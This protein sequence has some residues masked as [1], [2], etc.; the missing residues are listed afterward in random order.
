MTAFIA[1]ITAA[2]LFAIALPACVDDAPPATPETRAGES[3]ADPVAAAQESARLHEWLEAAF[4]EQLAFSPMAQTSLGRKT[5]YDKWDQATDQA[6]TDLSA[7][8]KTKLAQLRSSFDPKTLDEQGKLNFRLYEYDLEQDDRA[9]RWRESGYNISQFGGAH[10]NTPPFLINFHRVDT[11]DDAAAYVVRLET[12]D[13]YLDQ[14]REEFEQRAGKGVMP[15]AWAF[16]QMIE[17][18][19][20]IITGAPFDGGAPSAL[21]AD[22][23]GKIDA[24]DADPAAK[25]ALKERAA[26]ALINEVKPAYER[27]IA[28]FEAAS[29][30][31]T[32]DDGVWKLPDGAAYY[33]H[34]VAA[35]TTTELTADE[36]HK[37][38]LREL[39]RIHAEMRKI[40]TYVGYEGSLEEFLVFLRTDPQFF[41]Q[42][43]DDGRAAYLAEATRVIDEVKARLD[44]LFIAK[45]KAD[46][47]VKR[48]EPF[49]EKAAGIAFY[50][51]PAPDGSR[52]GIYY[53]NLANMA[54]MPKFQLQAIAYHEGAPGHHMQIAIAQEIE[55]M[56]S[57]R[58]FGGYGAYS[59]GWGLY[60][61]EVPKEMGLYTD[62]YSDFGRL[63]TE[64]WRAVRLIVDT[65]IHS[66]KWTREQ[67]I[68]FMVKSVPV[69]EEQARKEIE[70]YVVIPG[71]A[72]AYMIGKLKIKELR[73]RAEEALR[74][75]FDLREFHDEVLANGS[76]PLDVLDDLIDEWIASK[77]AA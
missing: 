44:E 45:P 8:R 16:P 28:A 13:D 32:N 5:N 18:A 77:K 24:L 42:D 17:T 62:P 72:T 6:A 52:P 53:V 55:T 60:S 71:Q 37:I 66:K 20:N 23:T 2:S 46:L 61:E 33:D 11:L 39:D 76:V 36:I 31:A 25:T 9:Y 70:R 15:P 30:N 50:N 49:R 56:P 48:V 21:Y 59:E 73:A 7:W 41:Y 29:Q 40:M 47:V 54:A 67:A 14:N 12:M 58:R 35:A 22:I 68:D 69:S 26:A 34:Q 51:R 3:P 74:D 43:T 75:D 64:A 10:Q 65:G 27:M 1:R 19:R 63:G 57:F 4:E 38:G